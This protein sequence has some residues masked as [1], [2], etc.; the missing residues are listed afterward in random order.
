MPVRAKQAFFYLFRNRYPRW[1]PLPKG[2]TSIWEQFWE[3]KK[4][5]WGLK[6]AKKAELTVSE[7][8]LCKIGI[9][10]VCD[11]GNAHPSRQGLAHD[12]HKTIHG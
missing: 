3:E 1:F 7:E 10:P 4:Y 2:F 5:F 12:C 6:C 9:S 8:P 11:D